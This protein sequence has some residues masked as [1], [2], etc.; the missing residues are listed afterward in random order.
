MSDEH[1]ITPDPVPSALRD[2][3][4]A[5]GTDRPLHPATWGLHAWI[6]RLPEQRLLLLSLPDTIN[7]TEVAERAGS[8]HES[9][10][11]AIGA[12]VATMVWGYGPVGYGALRT[13]RVLSQNPQA[14][15]VF[16]SVARVARDEGPRAAFASLA[17]ERLHH[18]S[19]AIGTKFVYFCTAAHRAAHR[20]RTAPVLDQVVRR[21]FHRNAGIELDGSWSLINYFHY[22]DA[23]E[24]WGDALGLASDHVEALIVDQELAY[25]SGRPTSEAS[26]QRTTGVE[27]LEEVR[28]AIGR[29]GGDQESQARPHL[30]ALTRL[31][32]TA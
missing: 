25:G 9:E 13:E 22:L 3:P 28:V 1:L 32:T 14:G 11:R 18:L 10:A 19:P 6:R 21:W 12:F 8:A 23:L 30:E 27:A 24:C 17:S 20:D 4:R 7:R 29:R 31:L 2:L 16:Q 15:F 26:D 5:H